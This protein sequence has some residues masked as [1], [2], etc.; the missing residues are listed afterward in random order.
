MNETE[1][2]LLNCFAAAKLST[3]LKQEGDFSIFSRDKNKEGGREGDI[4]L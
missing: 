4:G 3:Y 1:V 2:E